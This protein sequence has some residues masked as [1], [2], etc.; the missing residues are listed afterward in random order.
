MPYS[1]QGLYLMYLD[2]LAVVFALCCHL[3]DLQGNGLCNFL[4]Y[5]VEL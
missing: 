1:D 5:S 2:G 4:N 3:W